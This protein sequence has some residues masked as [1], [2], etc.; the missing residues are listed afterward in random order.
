[1]KRSEQCLISAGILD[2]VHGWE[3]VSV[4]VLGLGL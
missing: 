4:A 1:M 2:A 3:D